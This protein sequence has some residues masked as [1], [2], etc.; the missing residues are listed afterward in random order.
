MTILSNSLKTKIRSRKAVLMTHQKVMSLILKIQNKKI[1]RT[2]NLKGLTLERKRK[3]VQILKMKLTHRIKT[4]RTRKTRSQ[5][6]P[7]LRRIKKR[8]LLKKPLT[9]KSSLSPLMKTKTHRKMLIALKMMCFLN[10]ARKNSNH[11]SNGYNVFQIIPENYYES[12][13]AIIHF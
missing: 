6:K 5:S 3:T 9:K 1:L 10:S 4:T 12:S 11:L 13:F 2:L 7:R 8:K